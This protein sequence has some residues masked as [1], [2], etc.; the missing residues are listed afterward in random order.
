MAQ[1]KNFVW[2][3]EDKQATQ[4]SGGTKVYTPIPGPQ[5]FDPAKT[6]TNADCSQATY[7]QAARNLNPKTQKEWD[8]TVYAFTFVANVEG[9]TL[10]VAHHAHIKGKITDQA[11]WGPG[12]SY[13]PG[14]FGPLSQGGTG[15]ALK[16]PAAAVTHL[17][18]TYHA[19]LDQAVQQD[20]DLKGGVIFKGTF[21][22]DQRYPH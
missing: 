10:C 5:N 13:I 21:P 4:A 14:F 6:I 12:N 22:G 8:Y 7:V 3:I 9:F 19:A 18:N 16:T 11:S 2:Q 20:K 17:Y 15:Y 1:V